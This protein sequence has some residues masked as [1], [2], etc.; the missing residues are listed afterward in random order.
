MVLGTAPSQAAGMSAGPI[1]AYFELGEK[2][3]SI[4][5]LSTIRQTTAA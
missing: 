3:C 5:L 1:L 2:R 4:V